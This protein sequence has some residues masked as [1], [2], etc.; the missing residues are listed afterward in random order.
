MSIFREIPPTAGFALYARDF[1]SL[2]DSRKRKG[3]LEDDFKNY[4]NVNY[5][6][7]TCSGT[8][9]FYLILEVLKDL[10]GKKTVVIPSF[11]CPLLPLAVKRAGLDIEVCDINQDDFGFNIKELENLCSNNRDILAIVPVHLA[12]IPVDFDSVNKIAEKY[13]IFTVEDCAQALGATY[14][15]RMVGTL[16]DFS[17]FSLARGKGLT[18]YEGGAIATN[19]NEYAALID[20]KIKKLVKN[21]FFGES[22]KIFELF[23]YW[24]FYR[25]LLFWFVFKLPQ[26]FWNLQNKPL[27]AYS[28]YYTIDFPVQEVSKIRQLI[29]HVTFSRLGQEIAQQ[30]EKAGY[31]I[32]GLK[33]ASGLK[34]I[35][36]LPNTQANYPYLTLIFNNPGTRN[37]IFK[38]LA[39]SGLGISQIYTLAI[40]DYG[41]L[42][43]ILS[44]RKC[45][46]ARYLAQNSITLSTNTF[47][48]KKGLD[49][50]INALKNL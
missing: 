9:A 40:N 11:V 39:D 32:R 6:L 19:K 34:I 43:P 36:E 4:L 16:G 8:A 38:I 46:N 21:N 7:V 13:N 49:K 24:V 26:I 27:K 35:Q 14:K 37:E 31:Y 23:G 30:R 17:F 29:G 5:A 2:F 15:A 45:P 47:L 42:K 10:S 22:L 50:I 28:D 33:S 12:G 41:Y 44:E 1:L 25:P 20:K 3:S 48:R 18:I